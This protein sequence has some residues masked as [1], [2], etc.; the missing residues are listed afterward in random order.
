MSLAGKAN[1]APVKDMAQSVDSSRDRDG[2]LELTKAQSKRLLLKTDLVVMPLAV[3]SMTLAFLDKVWPKLSQIK[4]P[5]TPSRM[6]WDMP[7]FSVSRRM[8][9]SSLKNTVGSVASSTSVTWL[10][11]FLHSG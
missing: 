1:D 11:S 9:T 3:L 5:L 4:S 2:V 10:W 6:H 8:P 7:L